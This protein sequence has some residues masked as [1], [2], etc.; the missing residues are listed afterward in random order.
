MKKSKRNHLLESV[1]SI[2]EKEKH[3][4]VLDLGCGDGDYS[5]RLARL[6]FDVTAGDMDQ[7]RFRYPGEI[8]FKNCDVT[9]PLPFADA[10]FD[11]VVFL[12]IIEH[13]R[14]PYSVVRELH[15]VLKPGGK[16]VLSTP[17]ILS[18]RSRVR[19]LIEGNYNYFREAPLDQI[20]NPKEKIFNL[21]IVPYRYHE[22]EYLL[23]AG[24]FEVEAVRTSVREGYEWSFLEPIVRLQLAL[25]EGRSRRKNGLDYT[26]IH[27][28]LKL[29]EILY[30]RHLIVKASKVSS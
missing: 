28:V 13:L 30:G 5:V 14:N 3:G 17:N 24:G 19:F 22:L 9:Q 27:N 21:H 10:S 6:G 2:F 18:L 4:A 15:R 12:E 16:L 29:P 7:E 11:Y 20:K 8:T 25:R 23:H 1:A 26:R